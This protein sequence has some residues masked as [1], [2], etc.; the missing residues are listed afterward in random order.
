MFDRNVLWVLGQDDAEAWHFQ[1]YD[2]ASLNPVVELPPVAVPRDQHIGF[3]ATTDGASTVMLLHVPGALTAWDAW[4]GSPLG[5]PIDVDGDHSGMTWPREGH[6]GHAVVATPGHLEL[7]DVPAGRRLGSTELVVPNANSVLAEGD[8]LVAVTPDG[9]LQVRRLPD[10]EPV[11]API[12]TP[13]TAALLGFDPEGRLVTVTSYADG[14]EIA[15]WDLE[16]RTEVGRI[17]PTR[18]LSST[19]VGG[20]LLVTRGGSGNLPETIPM[21]AG[22]W[23]AHLCHLLPGEPSAGA[24]ALLPAGADR[25]SPCG[26]TG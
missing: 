21:R 1:R 3:S 17:H 7:W 20:S 4:T 2:L 19:L 5:G 25:S 8:T 26:R 15:L 13:G 23:T 12:F 9:S 18:V 11:G 16:S 14:Q 22:D 24:A 10:M 6:P